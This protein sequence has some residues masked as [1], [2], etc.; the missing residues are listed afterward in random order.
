MANKKFIIKNF[1]G[2][3]F[4]ELYPK[5]VADQVVESQSK[6]FI[7]ES[8]LNKLKGIEA[9]ANNYVHPTSAGN[10]HVPVGGA[11]GQVLGYKADG[12]AQWITLEKAKIGTLNTSSTQSLSVE[13]SE[14]FSNGI[15]LHKIS[16]TGS[17]NDL[18]N[19]PN[20]GTAAAKNVGIGN[21]NIPV[22]D[23]NGKLPDSVIPAIAIT[24]TF[25]VANEQEMLALKAQTGDIAIRNDVNKS[26]I[27]KGTN[28]AQLDNW[29]VLKTPD[30]KVTSVN[31]QTGAVTIPTPGVLDTT[32]TTGLSVSASENMSGNIKL[33][34]VSKTGSYNDLLN[35]PTIP[36]NGSFSLSGLSDT[37]IAS[38]TANQL[39]KWDG[40]KWVNWTP[41]YLTQAP[42]TKV[43]GR[44]G[45]VQLTNTD[46]NAA[47]A[48]HVGSRDG[49]PVASATEN[50]FMSGADKARLDGLSKITVSENQPT[51]CKINDFWYEIIE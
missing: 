6:K 25:V 1:N 11:A 37:T 42:V 34:K 41:N 49:H 5:T 45:E 30:Q 26:Y 15:S 33:H 35:K 38:Q 12:E 50:G 10:K 17:Y 21:G 31:G 7:S 13:T 23:V 2:T 51:N 18:L 22:L 44:V 39:L 16:K 48:S 28:P 32:S 29:V 14:S 19:K 20:L 43:N 46:V 3:S 24:E 40:S 36:T 9:N 4:D 27:L 8:D 47:P